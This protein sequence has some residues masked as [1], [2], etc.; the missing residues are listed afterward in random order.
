MFI[1]TPPAGLPP[2]SD[3]QTC[4]YSILFS[5]L[6]LE[7]EPIDVAADLGLGGKALNA[8]SLNIVKGFTRLSVVALMC[9]TVMESVDLQDDSA[10]DLLQPLFPVLDCAWEIPVTVPCCNDVCA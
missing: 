10:L 5:G 3:W 4:F 9:I 2:I 1:G 8:R 6:E 7:R